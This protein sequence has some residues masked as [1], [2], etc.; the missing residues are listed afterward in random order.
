MRGKLDLMPKQFRDPQVAAAILG[1]GVAIILAGVALIA[2]AADRRLV[3]GSLAIGTA[4]SL[5]GLVLLVVGPADLPLNDV[6]NTEAPSKTPRI[7]QQATAASGGSAVASVIGGG[8]SISNVG[9]VT[10]VAAERTLKAPAVTIG[11]DLNRCVLWVTDNDVVEPFHVETSR[12]AKDSTAV[13]R[14]LWDNGLESRT[15]RRGETGW[16]IIM[17]VEPDQA[18]FMAPYVSI[19][20]SEHR[21]EWFARIEA[22]KRLVRFFGTPNR[23][24][25]VPE[26]S[27]GAFVVQVFS[28]HHEPIREECSYAVTQRSRLLM[29][30]DSDA[31]A[32]Q[33]SDDAT[34][35]EALPKRLTEQASNTTGDPESTS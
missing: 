16:V 30:F 29:P 14:P 2:S 26:N 27:G 25:H 6:A 4:I 32:R 31:I 3:G 19:L 15:L 1:I 33:N 8:G 24:V 28:D 22:R 5:V 10:H 9:N 17:S 34:A 11:V 7:V 12:F 23:D 13:L 35:T 18:K 21:K 20:E